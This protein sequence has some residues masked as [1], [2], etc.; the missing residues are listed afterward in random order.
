MTERKSNTLDLSHY[1]RDLLKKILR[2]EMD[3]PVMLFSGGVDTTVLAFLA[4]RIRGLAAIT[5][6]VEDRCKDEEYAARVAKILGLT[7][8]MVRSTYK[9]LLRVMP[10]TVKLL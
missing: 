1:L 9:D 4:T 8:I 3:A 2:E 5:V 7:H 10:Q 6:A